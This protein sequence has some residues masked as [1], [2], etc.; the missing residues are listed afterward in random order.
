MV[1]DQNNVVHIVHKRNDPPHPEEIRYLQVDGG[2][3]SAGP[4]EQ[5][6]ENMTSISLDIDSVGAIHACYGLGRRLI[7]A[8]NATGVWIIT[9]ADTLVPGASGGDCDIAVDNAD[10]VHISFLEYETLDLMYLGNASGDWTLERIDIH[11]GAILS[12]RHHTSI[13]VD[14]AGNP[15]IAYIHDSADNDLKYATKLS[16][17]WTS[18]RVNNDGDVGFYCDIATDSRG[19][20]HVVYRNMTTDDLMYASNKSGTWIGDVMANAS[21]AETSIVVDSADDVHITYVS[22]GRAAYITNRD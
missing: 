13:D 8:T 19:F 21:I 14:A 16:G 12:Q 9:D 22:E 6:N 10:N 18:V 2:A 5:T 7:Y 1:A 15:H 11:S 3:V 17:S 4:L 20:A